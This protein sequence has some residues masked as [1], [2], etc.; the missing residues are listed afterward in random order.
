MAATTPV[1]LI[2]MVM[3]VTGMLPMATA[4]AEA[5]TMVAS[6]PT[7]S[8]ALAVEVSAKVASPARTPPT[9]RLTLMATAATGMEPMATVTLDTGITTISLPL[10]T[11]AHAVV[12]SPTTSWSH[13]AGPDQ[14]G[15]VISSALQ[16][17]NSTWRGFDLR[18]FIQEAY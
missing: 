14:T 7:W 3:D 8:A 4:L 2:A 18:A 15:Y 1:V 5:G 17:F 6:G 10:K 9:D 11:A 12:A 16:I 13:V